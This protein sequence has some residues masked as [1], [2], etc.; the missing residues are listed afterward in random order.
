MTIPGRRK[1]LSIPDMRGWAERHA[2]L[3]FVG[4]A[5]LVMFALIAFPLIYTVYMSLHE[6]S[7]AS[8]RPPEY[9]GLQN[10]AQALSAAQFQGAV[11]RTLYYTVFAVLVP[12]VVGLAAALAFAQPFRGRGALRTIFVL[13][14]M[15]TPTAMALIWEM[16]FHPMLGVLNYLLSLV[17]FPP[18]LWIFSRETVIPSLVLV[19]T[20][21]ATPFMMLIIL[22]GLAALPVDLF[23]AARVDGANAIQ[24]FRHLT[25]PLVW[26]YIMVAVLLRSIDALKAFDSIYVLT[27]GGPGDASET[28]NIFLYL[29]AFA[30]YHI[31]YASAVVLLFFLLVLVVS[32][33]LIRVRRTTSW[34]YY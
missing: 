20:W 29:Q 26:P 4:P 32:V 17:G 13:P 8:A 24:R 22:G 30:Y 5:V 23:E 15:A 9:I 21:Y 33:V 2:N 27:Q 34:Q 18:A 16:M 31:G 1:Q 25:L 12:T 6:W 11:V 10:F 7:I 19:E 3:F 14:M 28:I